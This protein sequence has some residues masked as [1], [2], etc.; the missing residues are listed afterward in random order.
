MILVDSSVWIDYF[1]G[2]P[3]EAANYLDKAPGSENLVVGDIVL[4]E[5][6]QDFKHDKDFNTA[7]NLLTSLDVLPLLKQD[8]AIKSTQNFR[9]L[10]KRRLTVRKTI[11]VIIATYCIKNE[12]TLLQADKD[13]HPF[14][15]HLRLSLL[16]NTM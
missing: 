10:R 15:E 6:L 4:T 12:I 13:F 5:G 7:K 3:T 8:I 9:H 11:D 2:Q 1:N 16:P 14:A